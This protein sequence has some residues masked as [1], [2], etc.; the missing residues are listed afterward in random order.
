MTGDR[1]PERQEDVVALAGRFL[2]RPSN[3]RISS[4]HMSNSMRR[5]GRV[6]GSAARGHKV[7]KKG[8][9]GPKLASGHNVCHHGARWPIFVVFV[10]LC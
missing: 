10:R 3:S 5:A 8:L 6:P 7:V 9:S 4:A 1:A 2:V